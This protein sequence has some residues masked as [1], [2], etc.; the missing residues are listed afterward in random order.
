MKYKRKVYKHTMPE[1]WQGIAAQGTA[2]R[3]A[4][5]FRRHERKNR[6][7]K[8]LY[9]QVILNRFA[10]PAFRKKKPISGRRMLQMI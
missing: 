6:A 10:K 1:F 2:C 3:M 7:H 8:K 9:L 4:V 5:I